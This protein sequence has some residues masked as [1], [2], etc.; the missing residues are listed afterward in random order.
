MTNE[1]PQEAPK[2]AHDDPSAFK[3]IRDYLSRV[4]D[5]VIE[6]LGRYN[7]KPYQ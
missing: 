3:A 4:C 5:A 6:D 2:F 7:E 1:H